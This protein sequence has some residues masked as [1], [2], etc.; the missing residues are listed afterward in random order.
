MFVHEISCQKI[1]STRATG[2]GGALPR[3]DVGGLRCRVAHDFPSQGMAHPSQLVGLAVPKDDD[4][5]GMKRHY[6][7]C[8]IA[9]DRHLS[10]KRDGV[11][12]EGLDSVKH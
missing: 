4:V 12:S 6:K 7:I 2:S 9:A 10:A 8:A 11:S 1:A 5:L 3:S